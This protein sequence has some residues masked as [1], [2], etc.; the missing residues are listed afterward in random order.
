MDGTSADVKLVA[1]GI[2]RDFVLQKIIIYIFNHLTYACGA[3]LFFL[4]FLKASYINEQI[5][6]HHPM[7]V[8]IK[9]WV[10][11]EYLDG[12]QTVISD[13][14]MEAKITE[15]SGGKLKML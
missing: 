7:V 3:K 12:R 2:Y 6:K 5:D 14:E 1:E 11:Q 4:H 9:E 15:L 10:D 8:A 13:A